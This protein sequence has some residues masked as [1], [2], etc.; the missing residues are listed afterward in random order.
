MKHQH[1]KRNICQKLNYQAKYFAAHTEHGYFLLKH[2]HQHEITLTPTWEVLG[3]NTLKGEK[4]ISIV[5]KG[6]YSS[7]QALNCIGR[8]R[9]LVAQL[10]PAA[11]VDK[12]WNGLTAV[13]NFGVEFLKRI[14]TP[15]KLFWDFR[16]DKT[17]ALF[18]T[19]WS[20]SRVQVW[21]QVQAPAGHLK[22]TSEG[23]SRRQ[24]QVLTAKSMAEL[25]GQRSG[26][27]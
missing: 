25:F 8:P 14:Q 12:G 5:F 26:K 9:V 3:L 11:L 17:F 21:I 15:H 10:W 16:A 7:K 19:R 1:K 6:A 13:L 20:G 24:S 22:I 18:A 23:Y 2:W 27:A 4:I